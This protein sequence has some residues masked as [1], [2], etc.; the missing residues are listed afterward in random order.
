MRTAFSRLAMWAAAAVLLLVACATAPPMTIEADYEPAVAGMLASYR[1]YA[2]LPRPPG[3]P[4]EPNE[5]AVAPVVKQAVDDTLAAKGY[6]QDGQTPHFLVAW[7]VNLE[8]K[9][10]ITTVQTGYGRYRHPGL[11][12]ATTP[13]I[14]MVHEYTE[15]TL[16]V[17]VLDAPT[18][19]LVWRGTAQA[20]VLPSVDLPTREARIREAVRRILERFPPR[21]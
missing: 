17:D 7:Y 11:P 4:V 10:R 15:G 16:I 3:L 1:T 12:P 20:E 9:Q 14:R 5:M 19:S 21:A 8:A 6:R 2:W 18:R 13:P